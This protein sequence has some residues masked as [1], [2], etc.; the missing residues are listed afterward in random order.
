M[1]KIN[2]SRD[3]MLK[4]LLSRMLKTSN[5]MV[6]IID[7]R[8]IVTL[9]NQKAAKWLGRKK[10]ELAGSRIE[11]LINDI[12]EIVDALAGKRSLEKEIIVDKT[13]YLLKF[14]P[15]ILGRKR[16]LGGILVCRDISVRKKMEEAYKELDAVLDTSSD[17]MYITDGEGKT[18]RINAACNRTTGLEK[19]VVVGLNVKDIVAKGLFNKS[20]TLEVLKTKS[21]VTILQ[22]VTDRVVIVTGTPLFDEQGN[23][24]RVVSSARDITELNRWKNQTEEERRLKDHYYS[25][26]V[27]MRVRQMTRGEGNFIARSAAMQQVVELAMRVARTDSTVLVRGESG[28]GKEVVTKFIHRNSTRKKSSFMKINCAAIPENLLESE[29]FGYEPGAFTGA[30]KKGKVGLIELANHGTLFLDEIGEMPLALQAKLLQ[31]I[32]ERTFYRVGGTK[33]I[34]VDI[35]IIAATNRDL[36]KLVVQKKFREDLFYRLNVIPI[37]I[38][39]LRERKDDIVP[40]L[41]CFLDKFNK[42]H[43]MDKKIS[44][45][46]F[47]YLLRYRWPGNIRE[48][49][50]MVEQLVV[51]TPADLIEPQH[52]PGYIHNLPNPLNKQDKVTVPGVVSLPEAIEEVEKQLFLSAYENCKNTYQT[53]KMLGVSQP[54]VVRKLKKYK[55]NIG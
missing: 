27:E 49:E 29:L 42:K 2:Y 39:P 23:I 10:N 1:S 44:N 55:Q 6:L 15:I 31:V 46:A 14:E 36:E 43:Q 35:R 50:N 9:V 11:E 3:K 17:S 28:V 19:D 53:A 22:N 30:L 51:I 45:D 41:G 16:N 21:K 38:P 18:L 54:T 25:E 33:A 48:L 13:H 37:T 26:L 5:D 32:Q 34:E 20:S 24:W 47:S 52:L 4:L 12:D 40:L 7:S 8:G